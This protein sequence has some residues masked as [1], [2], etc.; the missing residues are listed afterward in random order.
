MNNTEQKRDSFDDRHMNGYE[1]KELIGMRRKEGGKKD[2]LNTDG[3]KGKGIVNRDKF[4]AVN[5]TATNEI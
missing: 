1:R 4:R 5:Y 3:G 2:M